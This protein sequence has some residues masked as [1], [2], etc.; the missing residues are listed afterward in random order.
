L[1]ISLDIEKLKGF[2]LQGDPLI[3]GREPLGPAGDPRYSVAL[4]TPHEPRA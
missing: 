2:Q 3:R 1:P 4:R